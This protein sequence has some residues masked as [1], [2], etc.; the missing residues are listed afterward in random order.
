MGGS[1][2]QVRCLAEVLVSE[3]GYEVHVLSRG[4]SDTV[5]DMKYQ[6]HNISDR[7][8]LSRYAFFW[9]TFK[10]LRRL[11]KIRPDVIYQRVGCAYTGIAAYY[12]KRHKCRMIWHIAHDYDVDPAGSLSA[13][14]PL[15]HIIEKKALEYGLRNADTIIAQSRRQSDSLMRYYQ[16]SAKVIPNFHPVPQTM[17]KDK[18]PVNVLWVANFKAWKQPDVFIRLARYLQYIDNVKFIM[19]G[20]PSGNSD[21]QSQLESDIEITE[22]LQ[23]LG[24]LSQEQ[25]NDLMQDAHIFVNT[26]IKEGFAN[27]FIQAWMRHVTVVSLSVDPD[28]LLLDEG[29]GVITYSEKRLAEVVAEL[30]VDDNKR[31]EVAE[32]GYSY[33]MKWHTMRNIDDIIPLF[34]S[35][36]YGGG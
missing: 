24:E 13:K 10:L 32:V 8:G 23:Y 11:E 1:Q 7:T 19:V 12:A 14:V 30:I 5:P 3:G 9:D 28:N 17:P 2:Y 6:L 18:R 34:N 25:V 29:L 20:K 15:M 26:S 16:R 22:N 4:V 36:S 31:K 27:T 35:G 33:A 21:W